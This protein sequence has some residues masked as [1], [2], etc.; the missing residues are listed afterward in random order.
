MNI[1]PVMLN[2][3]IA[4]YE[5]SG[6]AEGLIPS[7]ASVGS[8]F[9]LIVVLLLQGRMPTRQMII[10]F[11][12]L[13][14]AA[15]IF[16]SLPVAVLVFAA[17]SFV[18]G[19][20]FGGADT[21]Q[22][23]LLADW[24]HHNI[25]K[26]MGSMHA[27]FGLGGIVVPI[28]LGLMLGRMNWRTIIFICAV[29]CF[30][31]FLQFALVTR[32]HPL[33]TTNAQDGSSKLSLS[34]IKEFLKNT[35]FVVLILC[36]FFGTAAQN[37]IAV[38]TIRYV[39][40]AFEASNISTYCLSA[41]WL[42]TAVSRLVCPWLPFSAVKILSYGALMASIFWTV[43]ILIN[44]P[45]A[46]FV[47]CI[48]TGLVSGSCI[49]LTLTVGAQL[50]PSQTGFSTSLLMMFKVVSQMVSPIIIAF[51]MAYSTQQIGMLVVSVFFFL[52][53]AVM[54]CPGAMKKKVKG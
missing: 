50:F 4:T 5:L 52:N 21:C 51:V 33:N 46:I 11:G 31:L 29:V 12:F 17:L 35:S 8:L 25:S 43:A 42:A 48:L 23:A 9:S 10:L 40:S 32:Q 18:L 6:T 3:I 47:S 24:N 39:S 34:V 19:F 14:S 28:V 30:L 44:N 1:L 13:L 38:W 49:P 36:A 22:S 45:I 20:G 54:I 53:A 2:D 7:I 16:Q 26:H 15:L 27:I 37:G 41:F